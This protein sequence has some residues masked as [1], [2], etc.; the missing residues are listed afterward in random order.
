MNEADKASRPVKAAACI[1]EVKVMC[2]GARGASP[3]L[4]TK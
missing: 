2:V 3:V 4:K 1:L